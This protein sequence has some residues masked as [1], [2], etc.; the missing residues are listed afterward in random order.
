LGEAEYTLKRRQLSKCSGFFTTGDDM[1]KD[2]TIHLDDPA[3][4]LP[5]VGKALGLGRK[6]GEGGFGFLGEGQG[7]FHL[8][9]QDAATAQRALE[10][11]QLAILEEK[12]V[13]V[14]IAEMGEKAT[15]DLSG[16]EMA[17]ENFYKVKVPDNGSVKITISIQANEETNDK[18]E[19]P[20]CIVA[21]LRWLGLTK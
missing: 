20:G 3:G 12:D 13:L 17:A 6:S 14:I 8:L 10:A 18:S 2:L 19:A 5:V 9:V 4:S 15:M 7:V 21:F 1:P 16:G 11:G